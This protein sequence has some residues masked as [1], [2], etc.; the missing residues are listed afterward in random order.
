MCMQII[1]KS[2]YRSRVNKKKDAPG[3]GVNGLVL[4]IVLDACKLADVAP[5]SEYAA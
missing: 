5:V 2:R 4:V 1:K 3:Q